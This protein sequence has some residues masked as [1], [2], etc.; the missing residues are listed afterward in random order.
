MCDNDSEE[1]GVCRDCKQTREIAKRLGISFHLA[2]RCRKVSACE[3]CNIN[4]I[5]GANID[6]CHSTGIVRGVLCNNCNSGLGMLMDNVI[7][8]RN[9][10]KY[11][12]HHKARL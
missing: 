7:T 6:H 3:I 9:A 10:I 4:L 5:G 2:K 12:E 8:A 11:I 1:H